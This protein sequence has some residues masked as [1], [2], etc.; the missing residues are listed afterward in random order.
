MRQDLVGNGI[1]I[2]VY[3]KNIWTNLESKKDGTKIFAV[4]ET[5]CQSNTLQRILKQLS[6]QKKA[7]GLH[8][9]FATAPEQNGSSSQQ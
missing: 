2:E 6:N 7:L 1:K 5:V 9:T 4:K 8:V 3:P